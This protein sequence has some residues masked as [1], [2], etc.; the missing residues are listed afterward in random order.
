MMP[1]PLNSLILMCFVCNS[2]VISMQECHT[3]MSIEATWCDGSDGLF[4]EIW[5]QVAQE[6]VRLQPSLVHI[7]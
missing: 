3:Y 1:N 5:K 7:C 6:K 2:F 4:F